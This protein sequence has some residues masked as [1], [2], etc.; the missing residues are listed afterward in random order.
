M[1]APFF[2]V[3]IH[4]KAGAGGGQKHDVPLLGHLPGGGNRPRHIR[5]PT[6]GQV[7][8]LPDGSLDLIRRGPQQN[9]II[10]KDNDKAQIIRQEAEDEKNRISHRSKALKQVIEYLN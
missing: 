10:K 8:V 6:D 9:R 5:R 7:A 4:I 2:K 1:A 3:F